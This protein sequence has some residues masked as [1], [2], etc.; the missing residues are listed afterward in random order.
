MVITL[1]G[2][3]MAIARDM[4]KMACVAF[5]RKI[6]MNLHQDTSDLAWSLTSFAAPQ[7]AGHFFA[8][9]QGALPVYSASVRKLYTDYDSE[10]IQQPKPTMVIQPD[11]NR[12]AS[13]F[14]NIS[15]EAVVRTSVFIYE[16]DDGF[17]LSAVVNG[18]ENRQ[19]FDLKT[20]LYNLF[21]G[22]FVDGAF[23]P[24]TTYGDL[25]PLPGSARPILQLHGLRTEALSHLGQFQV[26]DI[27][28][29]LKQNL[30]SR[31]T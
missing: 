1:N 14:H 25:R 5:T 8:R 18:D 29:T 12:Y 15:R 24:V 20:G 13:M 9:L 31:L 19:H 30:I 2:F 17:R 27:V 28:S 22:A 11:M 6:T 10:V 4:I 21:R 26:Q 7:Q 23:L 16:A 3:A